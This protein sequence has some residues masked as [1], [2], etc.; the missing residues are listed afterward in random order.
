MILPASC[1]KSGKYWYKWYGPI[2]ITNLLAK[3]TMTS[4][5]FTQVFKCILFVQWHLHNEMCW[6]VSTAI[7]PNVQSIALPKKQDIALNVINTVTLD[8]NAVDYHP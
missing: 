3:T 2:Y 4:N 7:Q 8:Y 1:I 6:Y 5:S